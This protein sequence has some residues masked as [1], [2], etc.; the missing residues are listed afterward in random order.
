MDEPTVTEKVGD[1][2]PPPT[3]A[4]A[5]TEDRTLAHAKLAAGILAITAVVL[6]LALYSIQPVT[7]TVNGVPF[8]T[9]RGVEILA[10]VDRVGADQLKPGDLVDVEGEVLEQGAGGP[11]RVVA[12]GREVEPGDTVGGTRAVFILPGEDLTEDTEVKLAW[13]H[14]SFKRQ[15]DGPVPIVIDPGSAAPTE[16]TVGTTSG[17]EA[18]RKDSGA[19]REPSVRYASLPKSAGKL[20]A[21]TFDDGPN[22]GETQRIL[23]IL[24]REK[25]KATFFVLGTN[26]EKYPGIVARAAAE[27][28]QI[29]VHSYSHPRFT[30]STPEKIQSEIDRCADLVE[31]E[32]G[33][34]PT[35]IRPPYGAVDGLVYH[36]IAKAGFNTA[37]W[38]VD[39]R[40]YSRPG[41]QK[42]INRVVFNAHPGMVVLMHDGG[43][44]RAETVSALPG[45]IGELRDAGYRFV[46]MEQYA[47]AAGL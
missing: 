32:T 19:S 5:V 30:K 13:K 17:K 47:A 41:M 27:G 18:S 1:G 12:D 35:W 23:R 4:T 43:G 21:L 33:K 36:E 26:V 20:V 45:I 16:I 28:H 7:V 22:S 42:I 46:T 11:A 37:L 8:E 9:R 24:Q 14:F 2:A 29:A 40:D 44:N 6:A 34:R 39:P 10:L 25:V 3:A 15:G 31:A 38:T